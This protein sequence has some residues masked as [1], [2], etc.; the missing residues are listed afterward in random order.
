MV[1]KVHNTLTDEIEE[2]D[3]IS[4]DKVKMYVCGTT[5]YDY[6]HLGHARTYVAYDMMVR[7]LEW[8]GYD[9]LYVQNITDVGHLTE[10]GEDK[11]EKKA[12]QEKTHPMQVVEYYMR[13]HLSD[14]D[15]L[16]I[17]RP[18]I[19]PRATGHLIDMIEAVKELEEKGYAYE[20]NGSVYFDI[21]KLEEYGELTN[22]NLGE[23]EESGR[24]EESSE[25][26][27]PQD[28]AL[29]KKAAPG[30]LM[31]WDSPWGEGFPGWHIECSVMSNKYLGEKFDIH[32]GAIELAFPHH[33]NEIAQNKGLFGK[34]PVKYWVHT[35]LLN[36]KGEKMSKSKGNFIKVKEALEK[37]SPEVIRFWILSSH[38][39]SPLNYTEEKIREAKRRLEKIILFVNRL[40][41]LNKGKGTKGEL[42]QRVKEFE[43]RF[44]EKMD[45]D[46]N[47]PEALTE[48]SKFI[49]EANKKLDKGEYE[50]GDPSYVYSKIKEI[51][52]IF[53]VIP[54]ETNGNLSSLVENLIDLR[55]D[56][57]EEENYELADEVREKIQ[58]SGI[59]IEDKKEGTIWMKN[60]K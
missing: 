56:L 27:S 19:M 23:L 17:K 42:T 51:L 29:W 21:S 6:I 60:L 45:N 32:G 14:I 54:R 12:K 16:R 58:E 30:Q 35:G 15:K 47:T 49:N 4:E 40:R 20:R 43:K 33:E 53:Q 2:F 36:I 31:T 13:N 48:L 50:E 38:Y 1:L 44:E 28:F 52:D 46:F 41:K 10:E 55:E 24:I 37:H 9:V 11:V 59:K 57:R 7:Y 22:V 18:D 39:R 3:P 8:K 26:K 25:K 34:H 5:D